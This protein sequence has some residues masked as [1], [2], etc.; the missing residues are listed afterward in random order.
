MGDGFPY[1]V[2]TDDA[3]RAGAWTC[4]LGH[5]RSS[6][7]DWLPAWDVS[8]RL[9]VGRQVKVD[10]AMVREQTGLVDAVLAVSVTFR[11]SFDDLFELVQLSSTARC[12]C[13]NLQITLDGSKLGSSVTLTTS[14][15]L[16]EKGEA[17]DADLPRAHRRGSVL[18]RDMRR[19]RLQGDASQFPFAS[20]NFAELGYPRGAPWFI[21][22]AP[23]LDAPA[24]GAVQ[25][26]VN[27]RF[28][29]VVEAARDF[30]ADRKDLAAIRS[31]MVA[32]AGRVLI[33]YAL[34]REDLDAEWDEDSLGAV[35]AASL[36]SRVTG[37]RDELNRRR[38][39]DPHGW[40]ADLAAAFGLMRHL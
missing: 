28:P 17:S 12:E 37:T 32:D 29:R 27:D 20:A 36:R 2:A 10:L 16:V 1:L 38:V 4:D 35:L 23:E 7:P 18:W 13:L 33:E 30:S 39:S 3:V 8:R 25:F 19:C 31:A 21:E 9:S 24:M 11:S 22:I 34:G 6:L 5:G 40:S 14:L 15:V 26:F